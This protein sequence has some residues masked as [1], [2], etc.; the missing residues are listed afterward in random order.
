MFRESPAPTS[1]F[2][3]ICITPGNGIS[4]Q[5]RDTTGGTAYKKDFDTA[6][7][8]VYFKLEKKG[9]MFTAYKSIDGN[10]WELLDSIALNQSFGE[11]YLVG[12]EVLSHSS[13]SVNLSKFD[14]VKVV[15]PKK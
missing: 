4:L 5:W 3:M 1:T 15:P 14:N 2:V 11:N 7:L 10:R 12:L 8:P 13:H 6:T 9:S